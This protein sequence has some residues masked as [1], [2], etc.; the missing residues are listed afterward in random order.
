MSNDLTMS[1]Q[2]LTFGS[3]LERTYQMCTFIVNGIWIGNIFSTHFQGL[4]SDLISFRIL[5]SAE[6]KGNIFKQF[7]EFFF[8]L[9]FLWRHI[10][11]TVIRGFRW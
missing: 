4:R 6:S 10:S 5:I 2:L 11:W 8:G 3:I 1:F 7:T 9:C